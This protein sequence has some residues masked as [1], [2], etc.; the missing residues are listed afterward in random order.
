MA[1]RVPNKFWVQRQLKKVGF[2]SIF[3]QVQKGIQAQ[4]Y[5]VEFYC[6]KP[7]LHE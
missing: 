4:P 5:I 6:V 7:S 2:Q 3:Y 1:I